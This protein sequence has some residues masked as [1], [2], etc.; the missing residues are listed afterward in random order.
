MPVWSQKAWGQKASA[1]P[2]LAIGC[3][4]VVPIAS[5]GYS[6][7]YRARQ[8]EFNRPVALKVLTLPV[9]DERGRRHFERELNLAGRLTGHP[10]VVSVFGSGFLTDGRG[11]VMMEYCPGGSLAE[12]LEAEGTLPARDV[13]SIGVKIAGVLELAAR[14]GIVHRDVKPGNILITRFGEPA[15]SDFGVAVAVGESSGTTTKALTPAHAAPEMLESGDVGPAADQWALASTLY[16]LLAGRPP[17]AIDESKGM[18][19]AM[20]RVLSDPVPT[21]PRADVPP[22]LQGTLERAMAK[23][24]RERWASAGEFGRALQ[25][26]ERT[27]GWPQTWMPDQ[28]VADAHRDSRAWAPPGT[29]GNRGS[30]PAAPPWGPTP[31]DATRTWSKRPTPRQEQAPPRPSR[32]PRLLAAVAGSAAVAIVAAVVLGFVFSKGGSPPKANKTQ[33]TTRPTLQTPSAGLANKLKPRNVEVVH[34]E[35]TTVTIQWDDPNHGLYPYV[36]KWAGVWHTTTSKTRTV[37]AGLDPSKGYCFVVG[38]VYGVGGETADAAP[39]CIRG[40]SLS[41]TGGT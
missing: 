4:D 34:E 22:G 16:T 1:D 11:Y 20:L 41:S 19:A 32:R 2:L 23:D 6:I 26:L 10:N 8:P 39:V 3:T 40:G 18:L 27:A 25:Q 28:E 36:V 33:P 15:L 29:D 9:G 30:A 7:V 17:F 24:P 21:I 37:V 38:A 14:E 31:D 5:G 13:V 12:R 35:T